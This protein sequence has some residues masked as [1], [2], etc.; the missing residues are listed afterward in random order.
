MPH[1]TILRKLLDV[2]LKNFAT[3]IG[4]INSSQQC[5]SLSDIIEALSLLDVVSKSNDEFSRRISILVVALISTYTPIEQKDFIRQIIT[6]ILSKI[7]FSP[8]ISL[9]DRDFKTNK[10][11]S[12]NVSFFDKLRVV[13]N[14][15][16][17][18]VVI[19]DEE[20]ILTGFQ[21]ELWKAIDTSQIIGVSAPTSA[22]K[23]FLIYLKIIYFILNGYSRFV[24][25][26]P[27]LSLIS[28]VT[29]DISK[30]LKRFNITNFNVLNSYEKIENDFIFIVTQER[31][32]SIFSDEGVD[33][34][35]MLV[36]DE[37]QNIE[38]VANEGPD[39]SK[40]LFDVLKDIKNDI[41]VKKIILS[42]PRLK[43]IANMG[44]EIFGDVSEELTSEAPPVLNLTYSISKKKNKYFLN[45]YSPVFDF[46]LKI[47]IENPENIY[48]LGQSQYNDKFNRYLHSIISKLD[49]QVNIIFSPTSTQA[50]KSAKEY[51]KNPNCKNILNKKELID[52][53]DYISSSVHPYYDLAK[54]L[55]KGIA[56]HT[57]KTPT[58]VRKCIELASSDGLINNLF[59][60][61]TLMQGVNLPANNIIIRNPN[62]FTRRKNGAVQL[63]A[64][65]FAN[66]RGRAGRL[67]IDFIGRSIVL[68]EGAFIDESE[69]Q[70]QQKLFE[71]EYKEIRVGY[72]DTYYE[73]RDFIDS[74]LEN[75]ERIEDEQPKHIL[76]YI[77]YTLLK[78]GEDGIERLRDVGFRIESSLLKKV[79]KD[80]S[81][82]NV[83]K[84]LCIK[85]RYWD[86][87]DLEYLYQLY[88]NELQPLPKTVWEKGLS[89]KILSC[90]ILMRDKF[91]YYFNRYINVAHDGYLFGVAK[92]AEN[93]AR[94][95]P[96][97]KILTDRFGDEYYE[98]I[99]TDIDNEIIKMSNKVSFGLPM[100]FKPISDLDREDKSF[101]TSIEYGAYSYVAKYL[102]DRGV[103][104]ETA[105][106]IAKETDFDETEDVM[107]KIKWEKLY[108]HLNYW[109][110]RHVDH[111]PI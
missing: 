40:I 41:E 89:D 60:T 27:T 18:R 53:C 38:R 42:G 10:I 35:D 109:E 31:A 83:P 29:E 80:V 9:I 7:G 33:G 4:L 12:S 20:F 54:Y 71:D 79:I 43:N 63:S 102:I 62:L 21:T 57:G 96:F 46:P 74:A 66:L 8:S 77:R 37:V 51:Y 16:K 48:G 22:G 45:Q 52:L 44:F 94:E 98:D 58:H 14:D 11:Y 100:L 78:N 90:L 84:E 93:W 30:L 49:N 47:V 5:F 28:Q 34:I 107:Q 67:L 88:G 97:S 59:C 99:D 87:L 65:E 3:K 72:S 1:R 95:T 2:E 25:I 23:S 108:K 69:D 104:R 75:E 111:L 82:L 56:Y 76:T 91:P 32:L 73:N 106:K 103:P 61:T 19:S 81:N 85:N 24:Y 15:L 50:R 13:A 6:P 68:D 55:K 64:Y 101:I 105:I 17:N 110:L 39:R 92:T 36:V 86:P 26:V 70:E